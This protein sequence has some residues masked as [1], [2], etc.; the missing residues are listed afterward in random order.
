V[1]SRSAASKDEIRPKVLQNGIFVVG[2][3]RSGTSLACQLLESSGVRF[4]SD[5]KADEYNKSGYFELETAKELEKKL[6]DKAMVDENIV[7]LNK[8][9]DRLNSGSALTGLK[10]VH[11]PAI[12][13]YRHITKNLRVVFVFRHPADAKASMLRRG[14][15]TFKLSWLENNNALVAAWENIPKS[16]VIGYE[17]LIAG[18]PFIAKAFRKLGFNV[19]IDV[20]KK[21]EQS[22]K[23]SR[24]PLTA[25]EL[26]LYRVLKKIERQSCR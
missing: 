7:E 20:I 12:F 1:N 22:Q 26:A 11:I 3:P 14:I 19:N 24:I 4:L 8:V 2:H 25:E 15:S 21:D 10:I 23:N 17:S 16:I 5:L 18:R 9:V 13:F 6:L